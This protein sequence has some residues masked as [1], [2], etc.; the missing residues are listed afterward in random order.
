MLSKLNIRSPSGEGWTMSQE[1]FDDFLEA[2]LISTNGDQF[3]FSS[4]NA[5]HQ[6][7]NHQHNL[8]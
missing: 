7:P 3:N 6:D 8:F 1:V 5:Q 4:H 2:A